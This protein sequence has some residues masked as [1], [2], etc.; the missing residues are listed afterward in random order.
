MDF[1]AISDLFGFSRLV[2]A[3]RDESGLKTG[4]FL[5]LRDELLDKIDKSEFCV[6]L[7][8]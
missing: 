1:L 4:D 8:C 2:E 7:S 3:G 5:V 6:I